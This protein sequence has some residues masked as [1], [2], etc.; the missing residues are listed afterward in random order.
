[1]YNLRYRAL[2]VHGWSDYSPSELIVANTVPTKPQNVR[3]ENVLDKLVVEWDES[4]STGGTDV[5]LTDY[6]FYAMKRSSTEYSVISYTSCV[7]DLAL[8]ISSRKCSFP[9]S[10]FTSE[11]INL[12]QGDYVIV[13]VQT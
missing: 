4:A 7:E 9:M 11:P 10:V 3:T 8:I 6:K 1:M 2:N 13:K 5:P 12:I